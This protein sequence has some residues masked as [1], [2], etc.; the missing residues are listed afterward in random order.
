MNWDAIGA[1]GE[2]IGAIA[3]VATLFYLARQIKDNA[4]QV[5]INSVTDLN[6]VYNDSFLPIY[7]SH[8]NMAIW[9]QGLRAPEELPEVEREIFF[10]FVRRLLNPFETVVSQYLAG[11]LDQHQFDRYREWTKWF[12]GTPGVQAF[13]ASA[14]GSTMITAEAARFLDLQNTG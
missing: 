2:I 1:I 12:V 8:E 11:T 6:S 3:V 4:Q 5:R 14:K 13:M 9:V 7:N 10:L